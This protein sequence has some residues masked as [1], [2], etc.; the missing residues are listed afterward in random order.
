MDSFKKSNSI[1]DGGSSE[2]NESEHPRDEDGKFTNKE[3]AGVFKKSAD[4][5]DTPNKNSQAKEENALRSEEEDVYN[6]AGIG[7]NSLYYQ[8]ITKKQAGVIF[9][10]NKQGKINIPDVCVKY[11]Y[12]HLVDVRGYKRDEKQQDVYNSLKIGLEWLFRGNYEKAQKSLIGAFQRQ[13]F[14][15]DSKEINEMRKALGLNQEEE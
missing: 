6:A 9:S 14:S 7:R 2:F 12:N 13:C 5:T 8:S 15:F 11:M 10:A 4:L 3:Q 1:L